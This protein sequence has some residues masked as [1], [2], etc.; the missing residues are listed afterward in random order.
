[1]VIKNLKHKSMNLSIIKVNFILLVVSS[2]VGMFFA[3]SFDLEAPKT[4]KEFVK[5]LY[6]LE[7]IQSESV[8]QV[9]EKV[10]RA[11][12]CKENPYVDSP[13]SIGYDSTISAPH[14]VRIFFSRSFLFVACI[15]IGANS[16]PFSINHSF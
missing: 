15:C 1:M 12:F 8:K 2:A 6:N 7:I 4:M 3:S 5:L 11:F 9:M 13:Q 14:M 10:D 16:Q